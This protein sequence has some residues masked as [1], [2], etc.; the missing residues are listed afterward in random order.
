MAM[1]IKP[2]PR[3]DAQETE[4]FFEIIS[5]RLG[6]P[7]YKKGDPA[8]LELARQKAREWEFSRAKG[9]HLKAS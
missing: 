6:K 5:E 2:T 4:R 1:P 9:H 8:K 3:L 7:S